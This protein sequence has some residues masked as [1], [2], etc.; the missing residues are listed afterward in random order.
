MTKKS[1]RWS[2]GFTLS[3]VG[4]LLACGSIRQD[5]FLCENAV[6]HL[7]GCCPGFDASAVECH[8]NAGC[9]D[10]TTYPEL[11]ETQSD[12]IMA[13][14]C[15]TL[16]ATGVCDRVAALPD[17][18]LVDGGS[19]PPV[20]AAVSGTDAAQSAGDD[21]S[22]GEPT[23]EC[24]SALDCTAGQICCGVVEAA[25]ASLTCQSAPCASGLQFC[26]TSAECDFG[27]TCRAVTAIGGAMLCAPEDASSAV[28]SEGAPADTTLDDGEVSDAESVDDAGSAPEGGPGD[29]GGRDAH[30]DAPA[31]VDG[32]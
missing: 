3:L 4:V 22:P 12:C 27:D 1:S 10:D 30:A 11:D 24:V 9:L 15:A 31:T 16:R 19:S 29:S 23:I 28:P 13:E 26:A 8:Y 2:S 18:G 20:C 6:S 17:E 14:S 25:G 21:G 5:E 32:D 7:Q